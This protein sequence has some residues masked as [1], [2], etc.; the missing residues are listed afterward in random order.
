M[1]LEAGSGADGGG[2]GGIE[3]GFSGVR[4]TS[5]I[6]SGILYRACVNMSN[7]LMLVVSGGI[8]E[9]ERF[10]LVVVAPV[11]HLEAACLETHWQSKPC[12]YHPLS[13]SAW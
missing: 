9:R 13:T 11:P 1:L 3:G 12:H 7:S 8:V 10:Y 6:G 4:R 5:V 2:R